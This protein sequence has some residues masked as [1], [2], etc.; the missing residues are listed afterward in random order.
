[1]NVSKTLLRTWFW[2]TGRIW[3]AQMDGLAVNCSIKHSITLIK[4]LSLRSWICRKYKFVSFRPH[5]FAMDL[6][7][8]N[9]VLFMTSCEIVPFHDHLLSTWMLLF[10]KLVISS[11]TTFRQRFAHAQMITNMLHVCTIFLWSSVKTHWR[12]E[13][14]VNFTA[15]CPGYTDGMSVSRYRNNPL[16]YIMYIS[17]YLPILHL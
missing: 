11:W 1:M 12:N 16:I 4:S 8:G 13:A 9:L 14:L 7:L 6:W 5:Q 15:V 2:F 10:N 17:K 3:W